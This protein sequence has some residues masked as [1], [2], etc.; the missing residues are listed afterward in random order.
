[1]MADLDLHGV[2]IPRLLVLAVAAYVALALLRPLLDRADL[3]RLV[4]HRALFDVC[5]YVLVLGGF[6]ALS[7]QWSQS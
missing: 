1:M 3:Y 5:L 7:L 4:W 2:F 6:V